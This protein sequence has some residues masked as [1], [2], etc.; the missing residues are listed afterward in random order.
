MIRKIRGCTGKGTQ[1]VL[2]YTY[3][4]H[5]QTEQERGRVMLYFILGAA[6]SGKTCRI[7]D[8][9]SKEEG[10][11]ILL[12]PDQF[13]FESER[14][15]AQVTGEKNNGISVTGFSALS[16]H[17]LKKYCSRK[18][19]ADN[20][21]KTAIML[22]TV[23]ELN[24][25][26]RFYAGASGRMGFASVCLSAVNMLKSS[27][28]SCE[29][30]SAAAEKEEAGCFK[31]KL[32][33]ISAIYGLYDKTLGKIYDDRQDNLVLAA[34]AAEENDCFAGIN[35][36]IDG[37]DSFTGAQKRF[38]EPVIRQSDNCTVA[39]C[40][41]NGGSEVFMM[42]E[43]T[44]AFFAKTAGLEHAEIKE[45]VL[46]GAP[47]YKNSSIRILR[48]ELCGET[49][50]KGSGEGITAAFSRS[51]SSE[52]DYVCSEI[53]KLVRKE[54]YRYSDIAVICASPSLYASTFVS[55]AMRYGIPVFADL[56]EPVS[57]KPLLRFF[58]C[59][60][61]AAANPVGVNIMRYIKSGFAR[62][63]SGKD[64]S[65][66]PVTLRERHLFDEYASYWDLKDK[67]WNRPF[68]KTDTEDE[69]TAENIREQIVAPLVRFSR[70]AQGKDGRQLTELFTRFLFR[71]A[72]IK[73]AIQG[74]CQDNSTRDLKYVKEKT[75]EYNNL[76]R[77]VSDMLSSLY[78]T[79]DGIPMTLEEY[80]LTVRTCASQI[81]LSRPPKVLDSILF[82]DASRT[83]SK[84]VRAVFV[85]GA[86]KGAFPD[87][88]MSDT[89]VFTLAETEKL[90]ESA[91][92]IKEDEE[93]EYSRAVFDVYKAL[94]LPEEKLCVT[95]TGEQDNAAE[96][97]AVME[98]A[99]GTQLINIDKQDPLSLCESV[100]SAEKQ[101]VR[102]VNGC[103]ESDKAAVILS[104]LKEC[105][106]PNCAGRF[107]AI[108]N[109]REQGAQEHIIKDIAPLVF[110]PRDLSPTAIEKLNGC[111]FAYFCRYG[112][113]LRSGSDITMNSGNYGNIM[114][115]VMKYC[116][117]R[118]YADKSEKT[119]PN[120]KKEEI[121]RLIKEAMDEYR[122]E[123]L[124][125]ESEMSMRFNTLYNSMA[126]TAYY[127]ILYMT[128]ELEKSSFRPMLFEL[129]LERGKEED[130]LKAEPYSFDITLPDGTLQR[131][132]ISGTVDRVDIAQSDSGKQLRVIDYKTGTKKADMSRVYY[133]LDLQ[134]LLYLFALC[135]SN[136]GLA[137]SAAVY[138]PAGKTPLK[139]IKA[140]SEELKRGIW[141]DTHRENG[142]AVEGTVYEKE[143]LNYSGITTGANGNEKAEN[144][145][146]A[147]TV[148]SG[149]LD[150]LKGRVLEVVKD[151]L[152]EVKSGN[153]SAIPLVQNGKAISC[154]YCEF[155]DICGIDTG[156]CC[157]V[158]SPEAEIFAKEVIKQAE[159][160]DKKGGR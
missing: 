75:E 60:F 7:Y 154:E 69:K 152:T 58:D 147:V 89:S 127:L 6:G 107:E 102:C 53:K 125:A 44:K 17:I 81:S 16:E 82:G 22:R 64:G 106:E 56:P 13:V 47:R 86:S 8:T 50:E 63:P 57:E 23:K 38:L 149:K 33:D 124:L 135:D 39:L 74:Q 138:Y 111:K 41:D 113:S 90:R 66:R 59:L 92:V 109:K 121:Q 151:N 4:R 88:N 85:M 96:C 55:A 21:A 91:I 28:I 79:L 10:R 1:N 84:D 150:R 29:A 72:D 70:E 3:R 76:W 155:A 99:F 31:D 122:K 51:M 94:S 40:T 114:H 119:N 62:I 11:A 110:P 129:K 148:S 19:Y 49:G 42:C 15:M 77:T 130:G 140:P 123:Y 68:P 37:F 98:K 141:L 120:V 36:Y 133:G 83:R 115:Y 104:A 80:A 108:A 71:Q 131:V 43:K 159:K 34:K 117:E 132:G 153:V 139:D 14:R 52:A 54:G 134:L 73:A 143:I 160:K 126:R 24:S 65:T 118:I 78:E 9:I 142:F 137:P 61:A 146:S 144:F 87:L 12:V 93:T 20:T 128:A 97:F 156:S 157:E 25:S 48:D 95:F 32:S 45:T 67:S 30:L 35:I 112:L 46:S 105:D 103:D 145:F 18:S 2:L 136:S 26:L 100:R 27:G 158:N 5:I 116:F 101:Y